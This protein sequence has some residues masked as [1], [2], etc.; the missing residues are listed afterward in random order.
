[1]YFAEELAVMLVPDP[2]S[3]YLYLSLM[4]QSIEPVLMGEITG[5]LQRNFNEVVP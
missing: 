1:M 3:L 2:T 5:T 4:S